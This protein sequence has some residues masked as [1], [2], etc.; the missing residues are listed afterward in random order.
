MS[1][2]LFCE[3][4]PTCYKI[5]VVKERTKRNIKNRF[6]KKCLAITKS[7]EELSNIVKGH[8]SII[9]RK[10]YQVDM[11]LQV[12][13]K[14]N[15]EI[16]SKKLNGLI[17]QPGEIFS[18][19]YLIGETTKKYGYKEGLVISK[20]GLTSDIGG[21]LC[22]LANMIHYLVLNSP[23][24]VI[25]IHHHSDALFPDD[26]RRVPFGTGTSVFY[27]YLDYRFRNNTD[28]TVQLLLWVEDDM[29]CG[30]LRSE[31]EFPYRYK[32]IE[33]NHH[34]RKEKDGKFYRISQ[35]YRLVI[36]RR[37]KR[38]V[39][40]EL[41]LDNHSEVLYDYNQIPELEIRDY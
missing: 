34:F 20:K 12:N 4:S 37:T 24:E 40:K 30:E 22:Q 11:Q 21:G 16:A 19:W 15:L 23:L 14:I 39:R 33:E 36:D 25:E 32:L 17:I 9:L 35:V 27:N 5:S 3:I 38:E 28:Q 8:T 18:F 2:K 31:K 29:L 6:E 10:L 13:K 1:R 7:D 26:R 41:I